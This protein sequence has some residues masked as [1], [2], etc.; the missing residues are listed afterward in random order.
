MKEIFE[1]QKAILQWFR[2]NSGVK[3]PIEKIR[4]L[5]KNIRNQIGDKESKNYLY[6]YFFPL[7]R[8]GFIEFQG[9]GVYSLS[10]TVLISQNKILV[11]I[12]LSSTQL[13]KVSNYII[14][15]MFE[16]SLIYLDKAH[17][18][19]IVEILDIKVENSDVASTLK[20]IPSIKEV[21]DSFEE[22]EFIDIN[23]FEY[24]DYGWKTINDT[25]VLGCFR[26]DS[27]IA[28]N[29][30]F[31]VEEDRW[32]RIPSRKTNPD[33]FNWAVCYS[34]I[35]N[36]KPLKISY[37]KT[38]KKLEINNN[39]FPIILERLLRIKTISTANQNF[40]FQNKIILANV[41]YSIFKQLNRILLN[42]IPING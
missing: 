16:G 15:N 39:H 19:S 38:E 9:D 14:K 25:N 8:I 27:N 34:Q 40:S 35:I 32:L 5:C 31:R 24:Y 29:R 13:S 6:E 17:E 33:S 37:S 21:L 26:A 22:K 36:E 12:N 10:N 42:K 1:G 30:Y 20:L 7:V 3:V 4:L 23:G 28:S 41:E 11:G 18:K 2:F